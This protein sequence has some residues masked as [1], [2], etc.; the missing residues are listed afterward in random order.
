MP[1]GQLAAL[2]MFAKVELAKPAQLSQFWYTFGSAAT[3]V[4]HPASA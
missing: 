4:E 2:V 3:G 1:A